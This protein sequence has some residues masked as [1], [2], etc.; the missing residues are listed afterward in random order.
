MNDIN[1]LSANAADKLDR[2]AD[3][4]TAK[5]DD[6]LSA[7]RRAANGALDKLQDGVNEL[8]ADAPGA[9]GRVAAQVDELTR[10]GIERA[11]QASVEVRHS[12]ERT[13]DRTVGYIKDEPVKSML[14]AAAT[15]AAVAALISLLARNRNH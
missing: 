11:R 3:Q 4:A 10:R 7:T 9:L 8:R 14:I 5:A 12:A 6:A 15:G 13:S 2:F 1:T